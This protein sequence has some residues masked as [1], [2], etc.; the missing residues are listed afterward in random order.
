MKLRYFMLFVLIMQLFVQCF[1]PDTIK[2]GFIGNLTGRT[3][4]AGVDARNGVLLAV[5][6]INAKGGINGKKIELIVKDDQNNAEIAKKELTHLINQNIQ[7]IIGHVVSG[8]SLATLPLVNQ[9]KVLM[10]SPTS[11]S[12]VFNAQDDY[13]IRVSPATKYAIDSFVEYI[14]EKL[15]LKKISFIYD[16]SN[17]GY[18]EDWYKNFTR[19]YEALGGK[20]AGTI[21]FN[22]ASKP[23]FNQL[24]KELIK[25]K[26]QA[27][28]IIA[29]ALDAA[30]LTQHIKKL[31]PQTKILIAGW[32]MTED[33]IKNGGTAV[34][35]ALIPYNFDKDSQDPNY[36]SFKANFLARFGV[37]PNFTAK[38]SYETVYMLESVLKVS[39]LHDAGSIKQAIIGQ[40]RFKGLQGDFTIDKNGDAETRIFFFTIKDGLFQQVK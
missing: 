20:S 5:E 9:K 14:V 11:V 17:K 2:I 29:G 36:L 35:G 28:V 4:D 27:A 1:K 30:M 15:K 6:E 3:S 39:P 32:A 16:L 37:S 23:V 21:T 24:A 33:L 22:S 12:N 25:E 19:K 26:P 18:S 40:G 34:E 10:V 38:Y 31:A 7:I 13:F 8:M